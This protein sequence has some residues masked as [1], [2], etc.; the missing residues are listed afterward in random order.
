MDDFE[1][2][3]SYDRQ[4]E[5]GYGERDERRAELEATEGWR[6]EPEVSEAQDDPVIPTAFELE[7]AWAAGFMEGEGY[8]S[9]DPST[10]RRRLGANQVNREPLDHL[11]RLFGGQIHKREQTVRQSWYGWQIGREAD[12]LRITGL[13]APWLSDARKSRIPWIDEVDHAAVT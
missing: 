6:D 1:A 10:G 8:F 13:L 7:I 4:A 3:A 11:Q 2:L 5:Q 9:A 12:V